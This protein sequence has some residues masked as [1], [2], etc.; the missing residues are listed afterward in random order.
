MDEPAPDEPVE[1]V[2]EELPP[3]PF[4]DI[5]RRDRQL[6]LPEPPSH[7][8]GGPPQFEE[9]AKLHVRDPSQCQLVLVGQEMDGHAGRTVTQKR[10]DTVGTSTW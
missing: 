7:S 3:E 9:L 8:L 6:N 1:G 4:E 2:A 10:M 5:K